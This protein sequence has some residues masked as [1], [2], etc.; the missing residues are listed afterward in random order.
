M[1]SNIEHNAKAT[2]N[3]NTIFIGQ[4]NNNAVPAP[5]GPKPPDKGGIAGTFD[6]NYQVNHSKKVIV[7]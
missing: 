1:M 4:A 3:K 6:P 5:A 7:Q 2:I